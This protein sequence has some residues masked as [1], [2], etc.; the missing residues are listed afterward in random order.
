MNDKDKILF[1]QGLANLL[2]NLAGILEY[3]KYK[4]KLTRQRYLALVAEGFS[5]S[6]ALFLCKQDP[7]TP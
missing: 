1:A 5:E 6:Q 4:A 2:D 7:S 3:E